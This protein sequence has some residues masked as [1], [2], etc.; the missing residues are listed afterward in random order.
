MTNTQSSP[1]MD[2]MRN[3]FWHASAIEAPAQLVRHSIRRLGTNLR[4]KRSWTKINPFVSGI[5]EG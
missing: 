2:R 5:A 4:K 3:L 1:V